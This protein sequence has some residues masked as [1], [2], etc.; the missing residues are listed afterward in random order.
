LLGLPSL[1]ALAITFSA[2][3]SVLSGVNY[4][5]AAAGILDESCKNL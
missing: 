4:A 5:S 2:A 3:E 1:P